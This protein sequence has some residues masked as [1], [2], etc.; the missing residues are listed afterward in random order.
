MACGVFSF[1]HL[2]LPQSVHVIDGWDSHWEF[3]QSI[4]LCKVNKRMA[5]YSRCSFY[6]P[7]LLNMHCSH[8]LMLF[9]HPS[10]AHSVTIPSVERTRR[11]TPFLPTINFKTQL[12]PFLFF[13]QF[14]RLSAFWLAT[15]FQIPISL[16][17]PSRSRNFLRRYGRKRLSNIFTS[18]LCSLISVPSSY[19][20]TFFLCRRYFDLVRFDLLKKRKCL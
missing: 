9:Q 11:R 17:L 4:F 8:S 7:W 3:K 12:Q 1:W 5:S 2:E 16:L 6:L 13:Y 14:F 15:Y 10:H 18:I 19:T 20:L